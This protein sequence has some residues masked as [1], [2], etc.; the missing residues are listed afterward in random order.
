MVREAL[1]EGGLGLDDDDVLAAVE[2]E[3][4]FL[5]RE[6]EASAGVEAEGVGRA[7]RGRGAV[8]VGGAAAPHGGVRDDEVGAGV[9]DDG[10]GWSEARCSS[11]SSIKDLLDDDHDADNLST[12]SS[13]ASSPPP[14]PVVRHVRSASSALRS[15]CS[16]QEDPFGLP[17]GEEKRIVLY[18][19]S[20]R[21]LRRTFEDCST[22]RAILHGFRVAVDERDVFMD[23]KFLM[24]LKGILGG[25]RQSIALPQVFIGGW[26]VGGGEEIL[27]LHDAGDLKRYVEGCAQAAPECCE[28]PGEKKLK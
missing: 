14:P 25:R 7:A 12:K 28:A 3:V 9:V 23:A 16:P 27:W 17:P 6:G 26:H 4:V 24:E 20:L 5:G 1:A 2:E 22:V 19:T 15:W 18:F 21:V 10:D 8:D 11:S 13:R